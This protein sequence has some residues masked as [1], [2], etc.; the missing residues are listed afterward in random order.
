MPFVEGIRMIAYARTTNQ[1]EP[2]AERARA[3]KLRS[4]RYTCCVAAALVVHHRAAA[5]PTVARVPILIVAR[6]RGRDGRGTCTPSP[7]PPGH[8]RGCE[9]SLVLGPPVLASFF[10]YRPMRNPSQLTDQCKC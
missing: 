1:H 4:R 5:W 7:D 3:P 6:S 9:A 10:P 2:F 8:R